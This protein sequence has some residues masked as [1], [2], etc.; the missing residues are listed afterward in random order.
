M[1]HEDK[2]DQY[3]KEIR[4]ALRSDLIMPGYLP[5]DK[6]FYRLPEELEWDE[7]RCQWEWMGLTE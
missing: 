1:H 5:I 3:Y 4:K 2:D 6:I 7:S